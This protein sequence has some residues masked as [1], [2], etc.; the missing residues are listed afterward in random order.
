MGK[1]LRLV[2]SAG[3]IA[4][5][6][7][8][9]DWSNLGLA[10]RT[11]LCALGA[12]RSLLL[13]IAGAVALA[14]RCS[15]GPG[16]D[17]TLIDTRAECRR[18]VL[19]P[20]SAHVGGRRVMRAWAVRGGEP[21]MARAPQRFVTASGFFVLLCLGFWPSGF[22]SRF[23]IASAGGLHLTVAARCWRRWR[24]LWAIVALKTVPGGALDLYLLNL[25]AC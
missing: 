6:A 23:R 17:R 5:L 25:V 11:H 12:S 22:V 14:Q 2:V 18:Y 19:Q 3:L 10:C 24:V 15:Q 4:W 1:I 16:F 13:L 8:R 7:W 9:T 20:V 21:Q